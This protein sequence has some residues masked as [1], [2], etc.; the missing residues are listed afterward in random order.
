MHVGHIGGVYD[1]YV[2]T[3]LCGLVL[4]E[5]RQGADDGLDVELLAHFLADAPPNVGVEQDFGRIE[6]FPLTTGRCS[7]MRGARG[8]FS[9]FLR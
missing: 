2:V 9:G 5:W 6:G 4:Q 7:G 8:P 1:R 3:P